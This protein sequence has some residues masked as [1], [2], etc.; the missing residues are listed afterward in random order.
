MSLKARFEERLERR[1]F[2]ILFGLATLI[3]LYIGFIAETLTLMGGRS[4]T[5]WG[6]YPLYTLIGGVIYLGGVWA[7]SEVGILLTRRVR[8]E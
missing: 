4:T 5:L 8:Q 2:K 7:V 3:Y 1:W 6:Y